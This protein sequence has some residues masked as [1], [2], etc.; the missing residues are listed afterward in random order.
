M[1]FERLAMVKIDDFSISTCT[2]ILLSSLLGVMSSCVSFFYNYS[3]D[4]VGGYSFFVLFDTVCLFVC[5]SH[6]FLSHALTQKLLL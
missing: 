4:S 6:L 3:P 5:L 1:L 2:C